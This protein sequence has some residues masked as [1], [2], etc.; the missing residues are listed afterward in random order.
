MNDPYDSPSIIGA[1]PPPIPTREEAEAV[2]RKAY[3][4]RLMDAH[5]FNLEDATALADAGDVDL[6]IKPED[7]A[8][9]E[10]SYW[11]ADE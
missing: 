8:D 6:A 10:I 5:N 7:A 1:N 4:Q 9:D 11:D 3:V 2:W